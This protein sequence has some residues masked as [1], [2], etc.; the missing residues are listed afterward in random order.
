MQIPVV[1]KLVEDYS[2]EALEKAENAIIEEVKPD[3]EVLG[4]DEGEQLTHVIAAT[5]IKRKMQEENLP[6]GKAVRAYTLRVRSS[7]S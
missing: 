2:I 4:E 3:I 6:L 1:K 7:I 5:W